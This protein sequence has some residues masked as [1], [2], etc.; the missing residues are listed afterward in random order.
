MKELLLVRSDLRVIISSATLDAGG[1]SSFYGNAPVIEVAGR[2][3]SVVET[4]NKQ[5][6]ST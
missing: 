2:M 1:F 5:R 3:V 4:H 6:T